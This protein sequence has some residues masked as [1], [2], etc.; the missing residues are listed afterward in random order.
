MKRLSRVALAGIL[1][2]SVN[3]GATS[4]IRV[5]TMDSLAQVWV[6][7]AT[8]DPAQVFCRLELNKEG[9]GLFT[10]QRWDQSPAL[11]YRVSKTSLTAGVVEFA[12]VPIGKQGSVSL[13]GMALPSSLY[14]KLGAADPKEERVAVVLQPEAALT[15]RLKAV[16]ERALLERRPQK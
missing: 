14:L 5:A 10:M 13:G 16:T 12:L 6:G 1:G 11:A 8:A 3:S 9:T 4:V 2:L 7:G 15:A